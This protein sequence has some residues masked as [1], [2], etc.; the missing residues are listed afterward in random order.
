[1]TV[2][3]AVLEGEV[4]VTAVAVLEKG[5]GATAVAAME[6]WV[7]TTAVKSGLNLAAFT[8]LIAMGAPDSFAVIPRFSAQHVVFKSW[9]LRGQKVP[10]EHLLSCTPELVT[11][12]S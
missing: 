1:M 4:V 12:I 8:R 10:S 5:S 9:S 6:G 11:S 3:F 7:V 2:A